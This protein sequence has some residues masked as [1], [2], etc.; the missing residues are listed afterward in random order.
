[1]EYAWL[2]YRFFITLLDDVDFII[3]LFHHSILNKIY[4]N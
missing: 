1:M 3:I 2:I 4:G